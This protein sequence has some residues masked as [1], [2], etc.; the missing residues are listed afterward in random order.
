LFNFKSSGTYLPIDGTLNF[1]EYSTF[2]DFSN[3][4]ELRSKYGSDNISLGWQG[5]SSFNTTAVFG[6]LYDSSYTWTGLLGLDPEPINFTE[7]RGYQGGK[8][9]LLTTLKTASQIPS[10]SWSYTAGSR[11]CKLLFIT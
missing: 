1:A 3:Q 6:R 4:T 10:L 2:K 11:Y 8:P 5:Q 7:Y 9:S